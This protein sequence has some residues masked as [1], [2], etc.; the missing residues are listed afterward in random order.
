MELIHLLW[1]LL[2]VVAQL[3]LLSTIARPALIFADGCGNGNRPRPGRLQNCSART[4]WPAPHGRCTSPLMSSDALDQHGDAL[5]HAD[6]HRAQRVA[7][8]AAVQL[9][10]RGR[11]QSRAAHAQRMAERNGTPQR[12]DFR[13]I[14]AEVLARVG[15]VGTHRLKPLRELARSAANKAQVT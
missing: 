2:Q 11:H 14:E 4:A 6:A 12:I 5:A 7:A 13:R 9:V 3:P 10:H 15:K 8:A 1:L